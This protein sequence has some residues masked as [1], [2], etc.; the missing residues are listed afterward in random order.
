MFRKSRTLF[1]KRIPNL[2]VSLLLLISNASFALAPFISAPKVSAANEISASDHEGQLKTAGVLAG[3]TNGNI[4]TY[5]ELESINFRFTLDSS[6]TASG[7]MI[8]DF[9]NEG[10]SCNFFDGSFTLGT[11]DGSAN[12][13]VP[14]TGSTPVVQTVGTPTSPSGDWQQVLDVDFSA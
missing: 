7:Q 8:V 1:K 4:K 2:L 12:A 13:V 11:H 5:A 3:Y 6:A 14:V 10:N 9:T